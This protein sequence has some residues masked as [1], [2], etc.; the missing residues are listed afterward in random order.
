MYEDGNEQQGGIS[1]GSELPSAE[2]TISSG[3]KR[4][5]LQKLEDMGLSTNATEKDECEHT[6]E[7]VPEELDCPTPL[8]IVT[9]AVEQGI[10][11]LRDDDLEKFDANSIIVNDMKVVIQYINRNSRFGVSPFAIGMTHPD[12]P[13][14]AQ[15]ASQIALC[16]MNDEDTASVWYMHMFPN[17]IQ[18]E[19]AVMQGVFQGKNDFVPNIMDAMVRLYQQMDN[20]L[21]KDGMKKGGDFS[22]RLIL[23]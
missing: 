1:L 5:V 10:I 2:R 14:E 23:R 12:A 15:L 13:L 6:D 9:P 18:I 11:C 20:K 17:K 21:M 19:G 3:L 22:Y 8:L 7:T 4:G 16:H